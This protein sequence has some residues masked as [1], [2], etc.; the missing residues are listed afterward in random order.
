VECIEVLIQTL[1]E[2]IRKLL[3]YEETEWKHA[4]RRQYLKRS[5]FQPL[6]TTSTQQAEKIWQNRKQLYEIVFQTS[7]FP[8]MV[9]ELH[10]LVRCLP[11]S[12][13]QHA[14]TLQSTML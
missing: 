2:I 12:L 10:E 5:M 9:E 14:G 1:M 13:R 11:R 6:Y 4:L 8:F 3:L 7:A